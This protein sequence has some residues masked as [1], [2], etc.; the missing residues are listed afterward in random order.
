MSNFS[1]LKSN[2]PDLFESA[3][4]AESLAHPDPRTAC[5]YARRALEQA[6]AWMY[7]HDPALRLPYQDNLSALIHEPTFKSTAGEAV[8]GK[9]RIINQLGNHA[10]HSHRP[11]PP[12]DAVMAVRE[13]FHVAYWLART[14]AHDPGA[15]FDADA[16]PKGAPIPKQTIDQLQELESDLKE[17][18]EKLSAL[19]ADRAAID[20]E[21]KR[22]REEV[23]HA[24]AANAARPDT[25]D[26][27]E[28]ETRDA[29]IDLLLKEAGW[30]LDKPQDREFEVSGMPN[31]QGK[32][33]ADYVLWGDDGKPLAVVEAKRTKRDPRVGQ[34]QA[35]LYADCLERQFGRRPVIFY[36]N[37]YDHWIWDDASYPPRA[38]QGFL[39]KDELELLLQR[40]TTRLSLAGARIDPAIVERYYHTRAIRR[41]GE[42]FEKDHDRKALVVMATGAG[43]TR[44]AIA[45]C[46]LL[47]RCNWVK[48]VLFLADR[49]ALVRQAVGV[50]KKHLP[51][52]SP[53]NLVTEKDVEGRVYVSTYPTMMG[54]IDETAD[55]RRRFGV[56]HFDLVI[57]DEAHR[58]VYQKYRAIFDYFD[59][60]LVGLTAT[61][62]D[63]VDHNTYSLF[64]L[65][66]GVPTDVYSLEDAVKDKFLVPPKSVSVPLKFQRQGIRYDELSEDEKDEW[67]ALEWSEDGGVPESVDA[68]AVNKW[69]FNKDTVDKVLEHLMTRGLKVA[70]GDRLGKTIIFAKNHDH[71]VFI[72]ER[73]DANYPHLKGEFARVIDFQVEYAQSLID[74]FSNPEK[75]PHIAISVDMLDTGIDVPEVANLVFFKLV[76]SKTKFWQMVGRGTRLRP[77]LFGPGKPKEFFYIFDFCQNLEFFSQNPETTE[78]ATGASLGTRLFTTRVDLIGA[79]DAQAPVGQVAASVARYADPATAG[80]LRQDVAESLRERVAAMNPDNFVVRPRRRLVER[81]AKPQAWA[82]LKAEDAEDLERLAGLPSELA[83]EDEDAKRFD[84]L[85]LRLQL[86]LLREE[87]GFGR[88][89]DQVR[90]IAGLLEE[91]GNI[92]MVR[93]HM[94]LILEIQTDEYWQDVTAPMLERIRRRLRGLLK[95]IEKGDRHRVYTDFEDVI[96]EGSAVDLD[97]FGAGADFEKFRDKARQFLRAHEDH[98]AIHKLRWNEPL[99]PTDLAELERMLIAAGVGTAA[100]LTRAKQESQGLGLFIRSMVGLDREAAKRALGGFLAGKSPSANQVEFI[101]LIVDHLTEHGVMEPGLLYSSPFTDVNPHGP[102]G[103]FTETQ[104]GELV[105][106]LN[107]IRDRAA[108]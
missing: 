55:G 30:E 93:D 51:A 56:G 59:S 62:K 97:G 66:T 27:S 10:V 40:R 92:P 15:T 80:E 89:R 81:Y 99:T 78:G 84:L 83:D 96:G 12:S 44:T 108:S 8:F 45:L 42:A 47:M 16:L 3:A 53:V 79:L 100:D 37:G 107:G 49:V 25:H 104:V 36:T 34:Q 73:F 63:D 26:Y 46:D 58:S 43:K 39:K 21:L 82:A 57:I 86:A 18:D 75:A 28:A 98:V 20:E 41:I 32:G 60:L 69:L 2:W 106:V 22:L 72:A 38:A 52:S 85:M 54:L 87:R 61:P 76:R 70:G 11:V 23:A 5:F 48:R 67:D 29:F 105:S 6:V 88:L 7:K 94:A 19:L 68:G 24:K 74:D 77:D 50:F 64:E 103:V 1:F 35:K 101:N 95:L 91:K 65:E 14:Y 17:R 4:K 90:N 31:A 13:L 102:E 9:A 71:A 33:Y